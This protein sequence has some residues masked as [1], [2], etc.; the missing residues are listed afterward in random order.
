[1]S[2]LEFKAASRDGV[3]EDWPISYADLAPYYDRVE[4]FLRVCGTAEGLAQVPDGPLPRAAAALAA[5]SAASRRAVEERWSDRRGDPAPGSP[6]RPPRRCS[7]PALP[8]GRLTLYSDS[9]ASRVL[10]GA[11]GAPRR[12]GS[13][14][15][16]ARAAPNG[17]CA[18]RAVVLCA[19]AIE[20]T[21]LLLNSATDQHPDGLA[22][23]SGA[24][25]R[26]LMDHT[27]GIGFDGIAAPAR[28]RV[29]PSA[30]L[31]RL[32][33]ARLPQRR[34]RTRR[35]LRCAATGSSCRS[36]PLAGGLR[37]GCAAAAGAP[38]RASGCAPSARCCPAS[39]TGSR[40]TP[41][42]TDAWGIPD[43]PHRLPPTARTSR[44]WRP[45]SV[46]RLREMVEAAGFEIERSLPGAGAARALDP[47]DGHRADGQRP[48]ELGPRPR[49][50]A[51]WDVP[52]LFVTDGACFT[53]GGFQNPTL[54]MMALTVG[55]ARTSSRGGSWSEL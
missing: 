39:R 52:N 50:T 16:S 7:Q 47:R 25:G 51:A 35:R 40:S 28:R 9:V 27:Y 26:Y 29:R 34:P 15:S 43:R 49:T 20:S 30:G 54:T 24:L 3:G 48:R 41:S 45:T 6:R 22:N 1:M 33:R 10:V 11:D 32:P 21:R 4:R 44:R 42:K 8:T 19:S 38:R 17:R 23:S 12:A 37:A 18:R 14:S 2:D 53:S 31:L 5:A 55:P 36:T 13:L 46:A